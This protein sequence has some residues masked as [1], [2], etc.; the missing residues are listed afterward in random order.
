M[1]IQHYAKLGK[2]TYWSRWSRISSV[3]VGQNPYPANIEKQSTYI[4][5]HIRVDWPKTA[6]ASGYQVKYADNS[7][8]NGAKRGLCQRQ[9]YFYK[10]AYRPKNGERHNT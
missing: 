4:G 10:D 8:M 3:T 6:G 2:A 9:Q 5:S 7:G 1:Q